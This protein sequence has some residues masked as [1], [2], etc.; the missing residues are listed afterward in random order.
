MAKFSRF[1]RYWAEKFCHFVIE[2]WS[3][4]CTL[5]ENLKR[6]IFGN[7]SFRWSFFSKFQIFR[8][9]KSEMESEFDNHFQPAPFG[10]NQSVLSSKLYSW[11]RFPRTLIFDRNWANI[12][13]FTTDHSKSPIISFV[14]MCKIDQRTGMQSLV[15]VFQ[16]SK[17]KWRGPLRPPPLPSMRRGLT[18]S[19]PG[20]E[21]QYRFDLML[22]LFHTKH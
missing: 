9:L 22:S 21:I 18:K 15:F 3:F 13:S 1:S 8:N 10:E 20:R 5:F 16:L 12:T 17:D 14:R 7:K 6:H 11:R 4:I 2:K 19:S